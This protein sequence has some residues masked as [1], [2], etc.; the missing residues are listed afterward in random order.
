MLQ[1]YGHYQRPHL[2]FLFPLSYQGLLS[3]ARIYII[4]N[5]QETVRYDWLYDGDRN[6][7]D[8]R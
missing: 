1:V 3:G 7:H 5:F 4:S 2:M 8:I 6:Y